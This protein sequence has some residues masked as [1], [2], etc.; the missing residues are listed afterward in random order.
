MT[1]RARLYLFLASGAILLAALV[2][3]LLQLPGLGD[4]WEGY[5]AL[6]NR[7]GREVTGVTN[8]TV[9]VN[10]GFR[11]LDTL[12][13]EMVLLT[14]VTAVALLLRGTRTGEERPEEERLRLERSQPVQGIAPWPPLLLFTLGAYIVSYG[15]LTPGG[16]FQG[17]VLIAGA[18][19]TL[20]LTLGF[21]AFS[22]ATR[23]H[24]LEVLE[25]GAIAGYVVLG[26]IGLWREGAF[27]ANPLPTGRVGALVSGGMIPLLDVLVG[28][29][30]AAGLA[31]IL[32]EFLQEVVTPP[33]EEER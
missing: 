29:A 24:T 17:G 2:I 1:S 3:A 20:Y 16:G 18:L 6:V 30:V 21:G 5:G 12:G 23:P 28:I 27:L 22:R 9:A 13:E 32:F 14:G 26:L 8:M 11:A 31:I 10:F 15:H 4:A 19:L 33:R 7:L 25:G